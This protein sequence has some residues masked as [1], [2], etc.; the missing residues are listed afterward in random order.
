MCFLSPASPGRMRT[1]GWLGLWSWSSV[2]AQSSPTSPPSEKVKTCLRYLMSLIRRLR[3]KVEIRDWRRDSQHQMVGKYSSL[4]TG[5]DFRTLFVVKKNYQTVFRAGLSHVPV[6]FRVV[7]T[8][9]QRKM[10]NPGPVVDVD[11][12]KY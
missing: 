2:E 4:S 12:E 8:V 5:R 6:Q 3:T 11:K 9:N 1:I 7:S 10:N